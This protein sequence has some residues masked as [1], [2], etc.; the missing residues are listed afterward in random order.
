M[1]N[2]RAGSRIERFMPPN[3]ERRE[4]IARRT[5]AIATALAIVVFLHEPRVSFVLLPSLWIGCWVNGSAS[6]PAILVG[7]VTAILATCG[8]APLTVGGPLWVTAITF[9]LAVAVAFVLWSW[10]SVDRAD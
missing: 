4:R 7:G 2:A 9:T 8:L 1:R 6:P 5:L 3:W 10:A